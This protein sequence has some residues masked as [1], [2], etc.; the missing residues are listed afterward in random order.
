M[1]NLSRGASKETELL[2][3]LTSHQVGIAVLTETD[4]KEEQAAVFKLKGY[5]TYPAPATAGEKVRILILVQ[6]G[7]NKT[8]NVTVSD[9]SDEGALWLVLSA[10]CNRR[11]SLVVG[12]VY[13]SWQGL[14]AEQVYLEDLLY[15]TEQVLA[16]HKRVLLMGDF[17]LD[18]ERLQDKSYCRQHLARHLSMTLADLGLTYHKTPPTYR[19]HGTFNGTCRLSTI[20]HVYS[21]ALAIEDATTL[22]STM[23]DHWPVAATLDLQVRGAGVKQVQRRNF[24]GIIPAELESALESWDWPATYA[25]HSPD[26]V[27]AH[28][29][30]GILSALDQVAPV[31]TCQVKEGPAL[32]LS[33]ETREVMRKRD[34]A[35][36]KKLYRV[37]RNKATN[38]VRR[39]RLRAN[40]ATL[41]EAKGDQQVLWRLAD[42]VLGKG[43]SVTPHLVAP[44]GSVVERDGDAAE[45]MNAHLVKKVELLRAGIRGTPAGGPAS[46]AILPPSPSPAAA[47]PAT[48]RFS[49]AFTNAARITKLIKGLSNT[50]ALGLDGIPVSVYKMGVEVLAPPVAHLVNRSLSEGQVP[51]ELKA[52]RII[53]IHKGK[54]KDRT[55]PASYRPVC[56]L[57]AV[58]KV[59]ELVV[60]ENLERHLLNTCSLPEQQYGFRRGR[61]TTLAVGTAQAS[62]E[63]AKQRGRATAVAAFDFSSA[64]DTVDPSHLLARLQLL[65][66]R[67]REQ[68]WFRSYLTGGTQCVDW[69]EA[70]S[71]N[72]PIK[73][74]V[75]QGSI[76]GPLLFVVLLSDLPRELGIATA[77]AGA[78]PQ[79]SGACM[80]ADDVTLWAHG[81]TAEAARG[82]L[83]E[84]TNKFTEY[85]AS[86][87]LSLNP[88]KTQYL[89]T[90]PGAGAVQCKELWV[91]ETRVMRQDQLELLG[92][93]FNGSLNVEETLKTTVRA[94]NRCAATVG[95]LALHLP[96]GQYLS[97]LAKGLTWGAVGT[98]AALAPVRM[99]HKEPVSTLAKKVQTAI[100]KTARTITGKKQV[101]HTPVEDLL[102]AAGLPSFNRLALEAVAQQAWK[103]ETSQDGPGGDRHA[104]GRILFGSRC[105][106]RSDTCRDTR[107][108][109]NGM[110]PPPSGAAQTLLY[111]AHKVWNEAPH[112]RRAQTAVSYVRLKP[113]WARCSLLSTSRR[114][115]AGTTTRWPSSTRR[116][117]S[118][119]SSFHSPLNMRAGWPSGNCIGDFPDISASLTLT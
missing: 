94:A 21:H 8:Y 72:R 32:Y 92:F 112:L 69:G 115:P 76:L 7:L 119:L 62:W 113:A 63:D 54:G 17:N 81:K 16:Q 74:G 44:D 100:N 65:G 111:R 5:D 108:S 90:G 98:G 3:L 101:D 30:A 117:S 110:I 35:K 24:K 51:S 64:F 18:V 58:S 45:L 91:D 52:G 79:W 102:R 107:A 103:A 34:L 36:D 49:F 61:S 85:A 41:R 48:P 86:R 11:V 73:F 105:D 47:A 95:R 33:K 56:I 97:H 114:H 4:L 38:L 6:E 14:T 87:C 93:K 66:I 83:Q 118:T 15:K 55:S 19:S 25:L 80:Y 59:L 43:R 77:A 9:L 23:T 53:P 82:T 27:L 89:V 20:D 78:G 26:Q 13:R 42:Q 1:S 10:T 60:K 46:P 37:L 12:G 96:R 70:R 57:P 67:G 50:T 75:R 39:D 22:S 31:R 99:S 109:R 104:L 88:L 84:M 71:E 28:I 116:S 40:L 2:H 29:R 106:N 68:A